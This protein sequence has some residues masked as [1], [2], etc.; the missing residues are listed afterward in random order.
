LFAP[1]SS[2]I[3]NP[4]GQFYSTLKP[5]LQATYE[6]VYW[7]EDAIF[8]ERN[9]RDFKQRIHT[10]NQSAELVCDLLRSRSLESQQHHVPPPPSDANETASLGE[11][12]VSNGTRSG[13]PHDDAEQNPI[14]VQKVYYPKWVTT[15]T[16][17]AIKTADGGYG[18]LF[19]VTFTSPLAARAFFDGL[20]CEKGPSLGT[21]FTLACPFVIL[22]H[23][24]E[25]EWAKQFGVDPY[26]VR[27]SVGL[28]N[29]DVLVGWIEGA[30]KNAEEAVLESEKGNEK[31]L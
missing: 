2:L 22:A 27:V 28:E 12:G 11:N 25:L 24:T 23:Y 20:G 15:D 3:L 13:A 18:G 5:A 26:L 9:S 1:A 19:S 10:I 30:L 4:Q 29:P 21:N 8:L 17:H 16:Y 31:G 6:D 7:D 14:V